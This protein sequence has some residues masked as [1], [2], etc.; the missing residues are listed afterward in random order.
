ML[1]REA[2]YSSHLATWRQAVERGELAALTPKK[3]GAKPKLD[4]R[5]RKLAEAQREIAK[6]KRRAERAELLVEIQKKVALALGMP[7]EN[8]EE[9]C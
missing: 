8:S 4:E 1:R 3:R 2:L 9:T 7:F 6:L 5:D